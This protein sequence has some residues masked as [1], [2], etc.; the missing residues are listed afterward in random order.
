MGK[1]GLTDKIIGIVVVIFLA[2]LVINIIMYASSYQSRKTEEIHNNQRILQQANSNYLSLIFHKMEQQTRNFFLSDF[3]WDLGESVSSSDDAIYLAMANY[4]QINDEVDSIYFY[5]SSKNKLYV[6]DAVSFY[7]IPIANSH[8]GYNNFNEDIGI[9][10]EDWVNRSK[11]AGGQVVITKNKEIRGGSE[12]IIS[13]S[14]YIE[15]PFAYRSDYF[16]VAFNIN[17][18]YFDTLKSQFCEEEE[19]LF[20]L[21]GKNPVYSSKED[22]WEEIG[23]QALEKA[24]SLQQFSFRGQI[25]GESYIVIGN[26][27]QDSG[28]TMVKAMP[29]SLIFGEVTR[30][31]SEGCVMQLAFSLIG[32]FVIYELM[33]RI[34]KPLINL[35]EMM[36]NYKKGDAYHASE[37]SSRSDEVGILYR[38]FEEMIDRI[39][40]LIQTEYESRISEKEAR[41]EALRTQLNPHFLYNTLQTVSGIAIEKGVWEIETINNSLSR[42]L[43]YSLNAGKSAAALKD[44][45]SHVED[46]FKI[47]KYRYEERIDLKINIQEDAL[48]CVVPVFSLQLLVENSIRHGLEDYMGN[49]TIYI[50]STIKENKL[51]LSVE[52]DGAGVKEEKLQ[53]L[54]KNMERGDD[55]QYR[56]HKGLLNLNQR[57]KYNFGEEYGIRFSSAKPHGFIVTI[58]IPYSELEEN[59]YD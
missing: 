8:S 41:L 30:Q 48:S 18:T 49:E 45:V 20:I 55:I 27:D 14:R 13:F 42:I 26:V 23:Q 4:Y 54:N 3:V 29:E 28:F 9:M 36:E 15:P 33:S 24:E 53:I 46:Y 34:T 31:F 2:N 35:A 59:F 44:E 25:K 11:E 43:R 16:V 47:Q 57:I 21:S 7:K 39:H 5:S 6:M 38:A 51:Y 50:Y 56:E 40:F 10:E 32:I 52:D 12:D 58:M 37:L 22:V 1:R 19:Y 17:E